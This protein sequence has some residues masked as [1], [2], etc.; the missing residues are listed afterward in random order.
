MFFP[1]CNA[2]VNRL[3]KTTFV[4][5]KLEIKC[6]IFSLSFREFKIEISFPSHNGN[7]FSI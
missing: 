5:L 6:K 7:K 1:R 3:P 4:T 2:Q